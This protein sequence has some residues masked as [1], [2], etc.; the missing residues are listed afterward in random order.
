MRQ[1][2]RT[3]GVSVGTVSKA[4]RNDPALSKARC[5]SIQDTAA[6]LGYR[7]NPMVA[8]LMAQ[9]HHFRRRSDPQKIAWIDLWP[10][11]RDRAAA[12]S[13][14]PI[15]RG[16]IQRAEELGYGIEVVPAGTIGMSHEQ[17]RRMLTAR[18]QWGL[19]IPPAPQSAMK[20]PL[21]MSG[22]I[23]VTIGTSLRE[24]VMHRV[25]PNHFQGCVLAF[26]R[27]RAR[28]FRRIGLVLTPSMNDRVEG[29]WLG[30]FLACRH[31]LPER[32][33]VSPLI[34]AQD[35]R[36]ALE[37]WL[38]HESPDAVLVAEE[39]PW[40][41]RYR[42]DRTPSRPLSVAWLMQPEG[43]R[44]T[45]G[46]DYRP[47]QLGRVAVELVVAQIHRNERGNPSISQTVLID[48]VWVDPES[49]AKPK[50]SSGAFH[51]LAD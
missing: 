21:D 36:K 15:L 22:L 10:A 14:K 37:G 35:D 19:I 45:W 4:L 11:K 32:D 51:G 3:A 40:P 39:F 38:H 7:P 49:C 20:Y 6:R 12:M 1:I 44:D 29:K 31:Q 26:E 43:G 42:S 33:H 13:V 23:G 41:V 46:V 30:A 2:A 47:E 5:R 48:A 27:M 8:T 9:L 18:G 25:S 16:A 28:G 24:P 34:T 50:S 17:L